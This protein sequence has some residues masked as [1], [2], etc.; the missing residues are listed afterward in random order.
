[1]NLRQYYQKIHETEASINDPYPIVVGKNADN[2]GSAN[3]LTEVTPDIAARM[4]VEG[5]ADL[6]SEQQAA[7]F[8]QRQ[9][10]AV[11]RAREAADAAQVRVAVV[12]ADEI[13]KLR[14]PSYP[15]KD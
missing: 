4:L 7:A 5:T 2:G 8:R 13:R 6:A 3:V 10:E 15:D 11:R 1:M 9:A 14:G 12:S